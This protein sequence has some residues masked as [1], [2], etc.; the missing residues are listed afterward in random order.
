M[1][2]IAASNTG[3]IYDVHFFELPLGGEVEKRDD[4]VIGEEV[5][6]PFVPPIVS[7]PLDFL[8]IERKTP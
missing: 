8:R 5:M 6:L 2:L 3:F 7:G 4:S 1:G